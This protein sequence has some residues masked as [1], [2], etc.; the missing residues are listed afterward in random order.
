MIEQLF[1]V[2]SAIIRISFDIF[3]SI[4]GDLVVKLKTSKLPLGQVKTRAAALAI[5]NYNVIL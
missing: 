4:I 2:K 5:V 3:P 1:L